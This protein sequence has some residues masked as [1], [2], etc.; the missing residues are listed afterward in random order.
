MAMSDRFGKKKPLEASTLRNRIC[1]IKSFIQFFIARS[2]YAGINPSMSEAFIKFTARQGE[3]N[4]RLTQFENTRTIEIRCVFLCFLSLFTKE[5]VTQ[6]HEYI[7]ASPILLNKSY[8]L[9]RIIYN[10]KYLFYCLYLFCLRF[11]FPGCWSQ[12]N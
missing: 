1:L 2:I 7:H 9:Y 12:I 11:F 6:I 8:Q 3:F 10:S 4:R 5:M